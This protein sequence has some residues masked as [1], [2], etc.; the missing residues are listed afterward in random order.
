MTRRTRR[1]LLRDAVLAGG[2]ALVLPGVA[3]LNGCM[4]SGRPPDTKPRKPLPE[5]EPFDPFSAARK[6]DRYFVFYYM[7]GGWDITL[8]SDPKPPGPKMAPQ[9][10]YER[11]TF[12]AGEHR[13]GPAMKPLQPWMEKMGVLRGLRAEALNH[14][15]AR[16]QL[17]TGQLRDP[18]KPL[19][20][21]VQTVLCE[22]YGAEYALPNVSTDQMRPA[23]FLGDAPP[24]NKVLRIRSVK[25]LKQL[26]GI[27][28][29][30]KYYS[31][32]IQET[33]SARDELLVEKYQHELAEQ[34]HSYAELAR[35]AGRTSLRQKAH[36]D[37]EL[38]LAWTALVRENNKWGQQARLA[39]E[40]IRRDL[41]P[42]VTVGSGEFDS[43]NRS[44][45]RSHRR[46]VERGFETVAAICDGLQRQK[47]KTGGTLLDKT[48][49]VV[50]SEFSRQPWINELGGKHHWPTNTMVFIG[51]GVKRT[52]GGPTVFG[53][54]DE[55]LYP[56]RMDPK[57]G[58]TEGR[59]ADYLTT[60]MALATTLQLGGLDGEEAFDETPIGALVES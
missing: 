54:T 1:K 3:Y 52:P 27:E 55:G 21:S 42:V 33:I 41:A 14:P 13:F 31:D 47:L 32:R 9:F 12:L 37:D 44:D 34:F 59:N 16:W 49:V 4:P 60:P 28:G 46:Y 43:H 25:Q 2:G 58:S 7:M 23:V 11:E 10:D 6:T 53:D 18:L 57:T 38:D 35:A 8:L 50:S 19:P 30:T 39:V 20:R 48:T 22:R 15:Q 45:Y 40:M 26:T 56:V 5:P 51:N 17:V 24:H 29:D 36:S